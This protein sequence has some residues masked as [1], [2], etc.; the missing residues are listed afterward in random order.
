MQLVSHKQIL[1]LLAPPSKPFVSFTLG[2]IWGPTEVSGS[3]MTN[4]V[5]FGGD[6]AM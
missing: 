5:D 1:V 2:E 3:S 4:A 6:V